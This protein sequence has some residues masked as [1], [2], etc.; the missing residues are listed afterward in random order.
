MIKECKDSPQISSSL[1]VGPDVV[2]SYI[3]K[4]SL[5][6][7]QCG[8]IA[9]NKRLKELPIF[10]K[11]GGGVLIVKG[12][13]FVLFENKIFKYRISRIHGG[14]NEECRL[15]GRKSPVRISKEKYKF[16]PTLP[17]RLMLCNISGFHGG[18]YEEC[19]LLECYALWFLQEPKFQKYIS[20]ASSR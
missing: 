19:C 11:K 14:D 17:N 15:L 16:S 20:L 18:D 3:L 7:R 12:R 13:N 8:N 2:K 4:F 5:N 9:L 10:I 6:I 1:T